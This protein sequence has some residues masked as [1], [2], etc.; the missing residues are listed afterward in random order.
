MFRN[1]LFVCD[2]L[3]S[4]CWQPVNPY[5]ELNASALISFRVQMAFLY[6]HKLYVRILRQLG[7]GL[8]HI[9]CRNVYQRVMT[10][11]SASRPESN[12]YETFFAENITYGERWT[13]RC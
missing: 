9:V 7:K 10:N 5:T 4:R 2:L 12:L 6:F 11:G 8:P 1:P 3:N 13:L